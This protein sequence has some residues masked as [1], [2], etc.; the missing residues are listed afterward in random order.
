MSIGSII[1]MICVII[2]GALSVRE[3]ARKK[4][5]KQTSKPAVP[6]FVPADAFDRPP[7]T[8][9]PKPKRKK[10]NAA[11]AAAKSQTAA[12]PRPA[13]PQPAP[14]APLPG[15]IGAPAE[16]EQ[17]SAEPAFNLRD[18]VIYSEILKPKFDE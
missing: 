18:A 14:T 13:T 16:A 4:A 12:A 9:A 11:P 1:W 8:A 5:G 2:A 6:P 3:N 10:R 17:T 7:Q 15:E